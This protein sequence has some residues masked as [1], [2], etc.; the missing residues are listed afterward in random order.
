MCPA[1]DDH[2]AAQAAL[3]GG[4]GALD[5]HD[6]T[7][8]LAGDEFFPFPQSPILQKVGLGVLHLVLEDSSSFWC[9]SHRTK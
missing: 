1:Q 8:L 4:P 7:Q 6:S 5:N 3:D 2:L 9:K